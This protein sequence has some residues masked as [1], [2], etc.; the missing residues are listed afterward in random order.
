[1]VGVGEES[2]GVVLSTVDLPHVILP[3]S[4]NLATQA[5]VLKGGMYHERLHTKS[6]RHCRNLLPRFLAVYSPYQNRQTYQCH[7]GLLAMLSCVYCLLNCWVI[8]SHLSGKCC[9]N[10]T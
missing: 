6:A 3:E 7:K 9:M 8:Y 5:A 2:A 4:S 10:A 1:M